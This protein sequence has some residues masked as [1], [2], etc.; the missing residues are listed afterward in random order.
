MVVNLKKKVGVQELNRGINKEVYSLLIVIFCIVFA[1]ACKKESNNKGNNQ[2]DTISNQIS[3]SNSEEIVND[4]DFE[5]KDGKIMKYIGPI[6]VSK[7]LVIPD[8]VTSIGEYA[9]A[10]S[11]WLVDEKQSLSLCIPKDVTIDAYAFTDTVPINITF[12]EGRTEIEDY[13][14]YVSGE[15][16]NGKISITLPTTIKKIGAYSF[17]T[18]GL[19]SNMKVILNEG[20]EVIGPYALDGIKCSIPSTVKILGD[21]A[22]SDIW[23]DYESEDPILSGGTVY[24]PEN[25]E[26]I[27][28][29]CIWIECPTEFIRIPASVKEI[30]V[31]AFSFGDSAYKSGFIV[32]EG[33]QYFCS[34]ENGWLYSK[35]KKTLY[36]AYCAKGYLKIPNG[37]EYI[38]NGALNTDKNG[39]GGRQDIYLPLSLKQ[40]DQGAIYHNSVHF[41]SKI[42]PE[43]TGAKENRFFIDGK[44]ISRRLL[45]AA[46]YVPEG[47]RKEYIDRLE[48]FPGMEYLVYEGEEGDIPKEVYKKNGF[49]IEDSVVTM[50]SGPEGRIEIPDGV[51][52]IGSSLF[53]NDDSNRY[54]ITEITFP[55]T[56]KELREYSIAYTN[57]T[58]IT[59][60]EHLETIG[61]F[62]FSSCSKLQQI[63]IPKTVTKIGAKA[64][65]ECISL[66]NITIPKGITELDEGVFWGCTGLEEVILPDTLTKIRG[67]VFIGCY[68]IKA[69]RIPKSVTEIDEEAFIE[70]SI[71]TIEGVKGSYA[72]SYAKKYGIKFVAVKE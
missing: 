31:N 5:I 6:N 33:N 7:T 58:S 10:N 57:I 37:V 36:Y 70:C 48:V 66:K 15:V 47:T 27:G 14:F 69:L 42:P 39:E 40:L 22:L 52:A 71:N 1:T 25:L 67:D 21:G 30:G 2:K 51:T 41:A 24:L 8:D 32:D 12:E 49:T 61:L 13:A 23:F 50:Y 62:A 11:K 59:L 60:P 55:E 20:L 29:N 4:A 56:V 26:V 64:F 3:N 72:E 17:S 63:I 53:M 9:F 34:D 43:I 19:C 16:N 38:L 68:K 54:K 45:I 65:S 46:V 28:S 35:D 44:C 18:N